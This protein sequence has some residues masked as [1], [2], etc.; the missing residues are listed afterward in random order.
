MVIPTTLL[1]N[2]TWAVFDDDRLAYLVGVYFIKS[3]Q[4]MLSIPTS[5]E[6]FKLTIAIAIAHQFLEDNHRI[7]EDA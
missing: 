3:E 7:I 5:S 2:P 1:T 6:I 4:L